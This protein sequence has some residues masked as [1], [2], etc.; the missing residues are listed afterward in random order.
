MDLEEQTRLVKSMEQFEEINAQVEK[1][2]EAS[3]GQKT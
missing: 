3:G 2:K 1:I